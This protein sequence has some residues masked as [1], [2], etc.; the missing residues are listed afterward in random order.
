MC[1]SRWS[2]LDIWPSSYT[3]GPCCDQPPGRWRLMCCPSG[4][5]SRCGSSAVEAGS[6][7]LSLTDRILRPLALMAALL[8]LA[9]V[10]ML[11]SRAP[12]DT[13]AMVAHVGKVGG[14]LILLLSL[15]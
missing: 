12:H 7:D 5:L 1:S 14:Y 15:M 10:L 4:S 3:R 11:Y 9:H 13:E 2:G 6:A 8:F